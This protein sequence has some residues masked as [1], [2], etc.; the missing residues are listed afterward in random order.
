M[1][2]DN[3]CMRTLKENA[4]FNIIRAIQS[5]PCW[6]TTLCILR[7]TDWEEMCENVN[8]GRSQVMRY[9]FL[10][11]TDLFISWKKFTE[12]GVGKEEGTGAEA[13]RGGDRKG[14]CGEG[15]VH[16]LGGWNWGQIWSSRM[17]RDSGG[18]RFYIICKWHELNKYKYKQIFKKC[19]TLFTESQKYKLKKQDAC[20]K[21]YFSLLTSMAKI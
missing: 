2:W 12:L 20:F 16:S 17:R 18:N 15:Q 19:S 6:N 5:Q 11:F 8:S 21:M 4:R 9:E 7:K 10:E 1:T 14:L 13:G 3:A